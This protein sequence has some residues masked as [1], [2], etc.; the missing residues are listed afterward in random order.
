ME[1][2]EQRLSN[3]LVLCAALALA[4]YLV[5]CEPEEGWPWSRNMV[6]SQGVQPQELA[7]LPPDSTIPTPAKELRNV[8]TDIILGSPGREGR[9][10]EAMDRGRMLFDRYC[11]V[12]HG[13]DAVG[14]ELTE[15]LV[16]PDLT[17]Q[18]YAELPD[19]DIYAV[20][21]DGGLNMPDYRDA[22]DPKDRWLV[23]EYLRRLQGRK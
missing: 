19:G 21:T 14:R 23:I 10:R 4:L 18:D 8:P 7:I 2:Q 11:A 6:D 20:L 1:Q 15:Y 16:T 12:C 5:S 3:Q 17:E 13:E 22:L 9:T